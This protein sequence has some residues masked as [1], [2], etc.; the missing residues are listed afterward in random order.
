MWWIAYVVDR[1][2]AMYH[3]DDPPARP[4]PLLGDNKSSFAGARWAPP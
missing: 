4:K 2:E 1:A 3:E